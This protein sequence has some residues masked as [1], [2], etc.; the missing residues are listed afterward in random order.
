MLIPGRTLDIQINDL[1]RDNMDETVTLLTPQEIVPTGPYDEY[2]V[3]YVAGEVL[4]AFARLETG[5]E[6]VAA[7]RVEAL[8]AATF[9]VQTT[10]EISTKSRLRYQGDDYEVHSARRLAGDIVAVSATRAE[11]SF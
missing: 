7:G 4:P 2:D 10:G 1:L 8:Q 11:D 9:T 3:E 6:R 5:D